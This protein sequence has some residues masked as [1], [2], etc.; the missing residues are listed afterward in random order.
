M[1]ALGSSSPLSFAPI[2]LELSISSIAYLALLTTSKPKSNFIIALIYSSVKLLAVATLFTSNLSILNI[3]RIPF[4]LGILLNEVVLLVWSIRNQEQLRSTKIRTMYSKSI[5]TTRV[6]GELISVIILIGIA[7]S[8]WVV[9]C[10]CNRQPV[11]PGVENLEELTECRVSKGYRYLNDILGAQLRGLAFAISITASVV[12]VSGWKFLLIGFTGDLSGKRRDGLAM[13]LAD[14]PWKRIVRVTYAFLAILVNALLIFTFFMPGFAWCIKVAVTDHDVNRYHLSTVASSFLNAMLA[15]SQMFVADIQLRLGAMQAA[16]EGEE[17]ALVEEKNKVADDTAADE[18]AG[19]LER[20]ST[21]RAVEE[22]NNFL[23]KSK[24]V[25]NAR[26]TRL[27]E[28]IGGPHR[29]P[30]SGRFGGGINQRELNFDNLD[31][32]GEKK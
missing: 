9:E 6:V 5:L 26:A 7:V 25:L 8:S 22:S 15:I 32:D 19:L 2:A 16:V 17:L 4:L 23:L 3:A 31:D 30:C 27:D 18:G 24:T 10:S 14:S 12:S 1:N 11:F 28:A 29:P 21:I 13:V 20:M